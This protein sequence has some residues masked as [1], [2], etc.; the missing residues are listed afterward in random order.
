M[1][2]RRIRADERHPFLTGATRL[3]GRQILAHPLSQERGGRLSSFRRGK[4]CTSGRWHPFNV[5]VY[6]L[7]A[8]DE[9]FLWRKSLQT[10]STRWSCR[11][12]MPCPANT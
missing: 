3:R 6:D 1:P 5:T 10:A 7:F 2:C 11:L 4:P 12:V 9:A 8:E